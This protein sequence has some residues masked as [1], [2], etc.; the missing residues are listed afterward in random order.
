MIRGD[1]KSSWCAPLIEEEIGEIGNMTI[2]DITDAGDII[3]GDIKSAHLCQIGYMTIEEIINAG[4]CNC[5]G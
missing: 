4:G 5:R 2:E 3:R 1:I